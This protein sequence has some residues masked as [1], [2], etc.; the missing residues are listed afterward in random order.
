VGYQSRLVPRDA[1]AVA[2][3]HELAGQYP[4]YGYRRIHVNREFASNF[5]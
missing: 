5:V 2:V 1:P 3:M 4:R